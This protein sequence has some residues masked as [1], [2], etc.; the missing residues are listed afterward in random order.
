MLAIPDDGIGPVGPTAVT[1]V[2]AADWAPSMPLS[3][4]DTVKKYWVPGVRPVTEHGLAV[5]AEPHGPV[6]TRLNGPPATVAE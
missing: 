3:T 5:G 2:E 6:V 1:P 4:A